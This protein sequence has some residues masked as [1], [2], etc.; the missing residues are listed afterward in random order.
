[1]NPNFSFYNYLVCEKQCNG[2]TDPS[3]YLSADENGDVITWNFYSDRPNRSD[4]DRMNNPM[5][6][7]YADAILFRGC[8][9]G[10]KSCHG[11]LDKL[12]R[13][14][15]KVI[16]RIDSYSR[17]NRADSRCHGWFS[18]Q[19]DRTSLLNTLILGTPNKP[20][21]TT[22]LGLETITML[23]SFRKLEW[24]W[25]IVIGMSKIG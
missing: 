15:K 13:S 16:L 23:I 18:F 25:L 20:L 14:L 7:N 22:F 6:V 17:H 10:K 4:L 9:R 12:A 1:M 19:I 21:K 24:K 2:A 11:P 3:K 8:Y 5:I